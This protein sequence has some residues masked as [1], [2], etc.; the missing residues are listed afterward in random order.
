MADSSYRIEMICGVPVV[1]VPAEID[2]AAADELRRVLLDSARDGYE[3]VVV[4]LSRTRF[5]PFDGLGVLVRAH[6]RVLANG[7]GLRLAVASGSPVARVLDLTGVGR[8]I[9]TFTGLDEALTGQVEGAEASE[10]ESSYS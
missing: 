9:P 4:D 6:R 1:A 5:C 7:G 8:F 3:T 2:D 10:E